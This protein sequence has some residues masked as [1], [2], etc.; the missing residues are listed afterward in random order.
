MVLSCDYRGADRVRSFTDWLGPGAARLA[1]RAA[2]QRQLGR[3]W[4]PALPRSSAGERCF[5]R[6]RSCGDPESD[7]AQGHDSEWDAL[8]Y[9]HNQARGA[10]KIITSSI[11][12]HVEGEHKRKDDDDDGTADVLVPVG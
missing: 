8:I 3:R 11:D 4:G 5:R 7:G 6:C 1:R 10:D 2:G 9:H 12:A